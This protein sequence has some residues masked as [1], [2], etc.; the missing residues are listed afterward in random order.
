VALVGVDQSAVPL[1]LTDEQF[2]DLTG[3]PQAYRRLK[4]GLKRAGLDPT[5]FPFPPDRRPYPGFAYLEEQDAAVFFGRDAQIVRGLDEIRRLARTGVTRMFVILGASGAGK[6]SFLR[7]GLWSRLKRDDLA[8][9]PL[10]IVRPERAA[11]SGTYGLAAALY[12][13]AGDPRFSDGVR[14][15]G[16][17]RSRVDILDFVERTDDGLAKLLAA[18]RDIA[19]AGLIGENAAPPTTLLA[20]DQGEELF[21]DEGRDEARRFIEILTKTLAADPRAMA[22]LVMRSDA[23][24]LV[25]GDAALAALPKD[26]FTLD[27][28]LEGSF[29][30]VIEGP[31]RLVEPPLA[32]DPQLTDAL[33]EDISGQDALPLLAFTLAHLYDNTRVDNALTL[34]GYDKIG[35]VKGVIDKTVTQ[36]FGEAAARGE[37][38]KTKEE[39]YKLARS[40]FIPH[41]AQVNPAGQFV[42]RVAPRNKIPDEARALVDR[43]AEQRLLIRDRRQDAEVI[44]VAHEALLRQPPFSDWLAE[45]REFLLWRDRLTQA[46]TAFEADERGLLAGRELVIAGSYMQTRAERDFEPA[47][48]AFIR[49]SIAADDK[50]RAEEAE[51]QRRRE[52]TE[53]EEQERRVR[54]AERI[55]QEQTKALANLREA[56]IAQS[57]YLAGLAHKRRAEG[58]AGTAMLLALEALPDADAGV[59]RP[60]V[61]EAEMQLDGACRE[62]RERLVLVHGDAVNSAAFSPD[63]KQIVTASADKTAQLWDAA[64]GQQISEPLRGHE[65]GVVSAAFSLDGQRIVTASADKTARLWDAKT[66]LPLGEPIRGHEELLFGAAFSPDGKQVITASLDKTARIWSAE[67]RQP[68]GEPLRGHDRLVSSAAFSPDGKRIVTA[69]DDKTARIWD[70]ATG[71]PIGEPLK[72]HEGGVNAAAFSPDGTRIVTASSDKTARLW[73]AETGKTIGEPFRHDDKVYRAAWSQDGTRIVTVSRRNTA[74][75]WDS[76]TG[77]P[78]GEP[79]GGHESGVSSAAFS[80]DGKR[81]VTASADKTARLWD[82]ATGPPVGQRLLQHE[83]SVSTAAFSPDGK[84]IVTASIDGARLWD[85]ATGRPMGHLDPDDLPDTVA[86]SP[87]GKRIVTTTLTS[88]TAR[89]WDLI[90]GRRIRELEGHEGN[91]TSAAFSPDGKRIVTA[92]ED[93]TARQWEPETGKPIGEP[94]R[95]HD[96]RVSSAAFSPDG[97][98]IVT[99]SSDQTARQWDAETGKPIGQPLR[100]HEFW[101]QS[102]AFSPD[103]KQ[104]VTASLDGTARQWDAATGQS[105]GELKGHNAGVESASFSPDGKRIV[106]ASADKTV[107]L[108]D[109]ATSQPIGELK[110]DDDRVSS[111]SFSPDGTRIVTASQNG[112]ARIWDIHADTQDL[113]SQTKAAVPR[114]LTLEQRKSFFLPPEPPAWCIEMEKPPYNTPTWKQ[115]LADVR[116]GKKPPLPAAS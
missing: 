55:I 100:G 104:I 94:L 15:R 17:P 56:Q 80:P 36:A 113:I 112:T 72:G 76:A 23:F 37:A 89:L 73:D 68:Q 63:G 109:A 92:S 12:Q 9:L 78:I 66:G 3:D 75:M 50:R 29:R 96:G 14:Q 90:S 69:S 34:A 6:S 83:D 115:W 91:M 86:F 19:Q 4:E 53:R 67:T 43:F 71:Q 28:M 13:I 82:A 42:R 114:C 7:A 110:G 79:L 22:I 99:T 84:Q 64:T 48:L 32:I 103:G 70:A 105:I 59:D 8:W 57:L 49:D 87:D 88:N 24:P 81:I 58:D 25:Q 18:L 95:G 44:E 35:R 97:R 51:E 116:A 85:A 107:R 47:D 60:Y 39:Q 10:P 52:A 11:I 101:V 41:L 40:A 16:L 98:R 33:L 26:T 20:I 77:R 65:S 2:I 5:S 31:A 46:R 102:A 21:N 30:A 38:P 111:A 27:M 62:V 1:D 106:T 45:D 61:P 54:D 93:R 108:W 74:R